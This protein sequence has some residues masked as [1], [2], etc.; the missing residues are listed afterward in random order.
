MVISPAIPFACLVHCH[1]MWW[2]G[3]WVRK[4]PAVFV[5]SGIVLHNYRTLI[6]CVNFKWL[7]VGWVTSVWFY[8]GRSVPAPLPPSTPSFI[9][10]KYRP[11]K[12]ETWHKTTLV[13]WNRKNLE[14]HA[15]WCTA[16]LVQGA[17]SPWAEQQMDLCN[18]RAVDM[19][20]E[21]AGIVVVM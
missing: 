13:L 17:V 14:Y 5:L 19:N 12:H 7:L 10:S 16:Q 8:W 4:D 21:W 20:S 11:L 18:G 2:Q 1:V 9:Y 6:K 15:S 3:R